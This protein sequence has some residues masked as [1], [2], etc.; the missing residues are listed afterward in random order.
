MCS[1]HLQSRGSAMPEADR[2]SARGGQPCGSFWTAYAQRKGDQKTHYTRTAIVTVAGASRPTEF[3]IQGPGSCRQPS[4]H[5]CC[6]RSVL[7]KKGC[8]EARDHS[9]RC[10]VELQVGGFHAFRPQAGS[11]FSQHC[12]LPAVVSPSGAR[13]R[14]RSGSGKKVAAAAVALL[15]L[16]REKSVELDQF[17][18]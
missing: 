3:H 11:S 13:R 15:L 12:R 14:K 2:R 1:S 10:A 6:R 5:S 16:G 17:F 18:H 8:W 9:R 4:R 7:A